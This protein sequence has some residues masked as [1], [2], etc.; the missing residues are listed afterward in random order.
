MQTGKQSIL[1]KPM[2]QTLL[3]SLVCILLGLLVGYVALLIINPA[4]A[5]SAII[6]VLKNFWTYS[7][8]DKQ[9]KHFGST[10][11]TTA[12]LLM[13]SLSVLFAYKVGLFNI[14]A[15]GQYTLGAFGALLFALVLK[16]PWYVCMLAAVVFGAAWGAIPGLFKAYFNVNEVITSIMFN[17]V[18]LFMVNLLLNNMPNL[19]HIINSNIL[20]LIIILHHIINHQHITNHHHM[21]HPHPIPHLNTLPLL[22]IHI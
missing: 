11:I 6:D 21:A 1:R 13:C 18:G 17:W 15:A 4:G 12:P 22:Q 9:L 2:V 8:P 3:A 14:G 19:L 7:K 10:L 5:T 16:C 20:H